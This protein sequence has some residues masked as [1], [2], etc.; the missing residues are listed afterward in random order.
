VFLYTPLNS[1]G[2]RKKWLERANIH[3]IGVYYTSSVDFVRRK[4][5]NFTEKL[6]FEFFLPL[7]KRF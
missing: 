2:D 5:E 3:T 6:I 4:K 1:Q 7:T